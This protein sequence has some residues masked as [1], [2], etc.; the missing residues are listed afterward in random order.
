MANGIKLRRGTKDSLGTIAI[1]ELVYATD[2]KELGLPDGRFIK[3]DA[4]VALTEPET[5][6]W[7]EASFTFTGEGLIQNSN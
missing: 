3:L 4:L 1:G 2:T 6:P 5:I 7:L